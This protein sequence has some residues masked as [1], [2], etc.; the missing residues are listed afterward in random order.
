MRR[1]SSYLV[2]YWRVSLASGS[3]DVR[4]AWSF[5]IG[6]ETPLELIRPQQYCSYS[7][8]TSTS[9]HEISYGLHMLQER[10]VEIEARVSPDER[11]FTPELVGLTNP[12][13]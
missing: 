3:S 2:G 6:S 1:D 10:D 13:S 12:S 7:N 9:S 8:V 11:V 5:S 4:A